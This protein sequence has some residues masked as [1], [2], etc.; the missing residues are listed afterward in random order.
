MNATQYL[1]SARVERRGR[2]WRVRLTDNLGQ[3][4]PNDRRWFCERQAAFAAAD[5]V[6]RQNIN[7]PG[8]QE[9]RVA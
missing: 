5:I 4:V 2:E 9:R 1:V 6:L 8:I 3:D 7:A